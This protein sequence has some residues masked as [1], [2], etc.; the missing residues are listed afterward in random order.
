MKP[1]HPRDYPRANHRWAHFEIAHEIEN[2]IR[3]QLGIT[4][5]PAPAAG[6]DEA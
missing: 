3:E 4:P 2:K 5:L 1:P 6:D